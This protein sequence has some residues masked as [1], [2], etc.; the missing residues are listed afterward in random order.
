QFE[1]QFRCHREYY[2][3]STAW[4]P[5]VVCASQPCKEIRQASSRSGGGC[6]PLWLARRVGWWRSRR[7]GWTGADIDIRGGGG[8]ARIG[9][10]GRRRGHHEGNRP[11]PREGAQPPTSALHTDGT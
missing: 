5:G 9:W 10:G 3:I 4:R 1:K 6:E 2:A 7:G 11:A 8:G